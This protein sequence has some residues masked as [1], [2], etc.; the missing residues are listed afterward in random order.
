M[1]FLFMYQA[2]YTLK[3]SQAEIVENAHSRALLKKKSVV[4]QQFVK[5][6][7]NFVDA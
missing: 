4:L 2:R 7:V 6:L 5:V 1:L 3:Y